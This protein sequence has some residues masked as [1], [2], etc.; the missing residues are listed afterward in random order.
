MKGLSPIL[1][2]LPS[3]LFAAPV[4][5]QNCL[6]GWCLAGCDMDDVC[7]YVQVISKDYPYVKFLVSSPAGMLK[8]EAD[9]Q[10]YKSRFIRGNG[11]KSSWSP[12]EPESLGY[13][14]IET[15]CNV[16]PSSEVTN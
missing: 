1:V 10:Q 4:F 9:C 13:R 7:D 12:A 15:A 5:T 2:T 8:K 6:D 3:L 16:K 11:S 14:M